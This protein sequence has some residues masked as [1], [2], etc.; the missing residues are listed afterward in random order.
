MRLTFFLLNDIITMLANLLKGRDAKL[1]CLSE[2][3]RMIDRL[4]T[5]EVLQPVFVFG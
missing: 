2:L 5:F 1:R 4:Q 3:F